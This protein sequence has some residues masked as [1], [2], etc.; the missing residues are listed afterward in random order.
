[1]TSRIVICLLFVLGLAD[2]SLAP[3]DD[4]PQWGGPQRDLIWRE[5]GI[6]D[7]FATDGMLP[8][9]WSSPIAEGYS[10]PAVANGKVFVTDRLREEEQE[11]IL[12]LDANTGK[13]QWV[14]SYRARYTINYPA[15]PRTTPT[16]DDDL[17]YSIGAQGH[18][19]C[20]RVAD[21]TVVWS[22]QFE[23]DYGTEL[24]AWGMASSPLIHSKPFGSSS[25]RRSR[26]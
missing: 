16:V 20:L 21:G 26:S 25:G 13:Q 8:R 17:V 4:W 24:P 18:L 3:A 1:M 15:G 10:G 9:V 6:V 14:H 23:D 19:F 2:C 7:A 5:K 22:K 11:R 12:C